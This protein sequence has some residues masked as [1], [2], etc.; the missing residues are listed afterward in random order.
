MKKLFGSKKKKKETS[1]DPISALQ[2]INSQLGM[3]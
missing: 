3:M 1:A 2:E